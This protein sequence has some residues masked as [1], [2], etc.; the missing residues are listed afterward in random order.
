M[1]SDNRKMVRF[2]P[3]PNDLMNGLT[4]LELIHA[5]RH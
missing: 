1:V 4:S 5:I 3:T 2:G